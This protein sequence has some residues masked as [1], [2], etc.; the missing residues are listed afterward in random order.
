MRCRSERPAPLEALRV[1]VEQSGTPIRSGAGR[2][3]RNPSYLFP[4]QFSSPKKRASICAK[5]SAPAALN[6]NTYKGTGGVWWWEGL[7]TTL[8]GRTACCWLAINAGK[9]RVSSQMALS[10]CRISNSL[11]EKQAV[12]S[13]NGSIE[14]FAMCASRRCTIRPREA[15]PTNNDSPRSSDNCPF[16]YRTAR[17]GF[18]GERLSRIK[19]EKASNLK[20]R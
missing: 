2:V 20:S 9:A 4:I 11:P 10:F 14:K 17:H 5:D 16:P 13:G 18:A 12:T 15:P 6:P 3:L 19:A 7:F 8:I 1:I